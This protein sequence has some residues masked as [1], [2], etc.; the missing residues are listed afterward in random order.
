MDSAE[1][2]HREMMFREDIEALD[3]RVEAADK[4]KDLRMQRSVAT[5]KWKDTSNSMCIMSDGGQKAMLHS[6]SKWKKGKRVVLA[7]WCYKG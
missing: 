5:K 6:Q 1:C 3:K 2:A 7:E 4:R